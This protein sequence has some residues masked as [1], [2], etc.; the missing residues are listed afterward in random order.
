MKKIP[1]L[2]GIV[3][4]IGLVGMVA[5]TTSAVKNVTTLFSK[6]ASSTFVLPAKAGSISDT[7]F[8][9]YW[10]SDQ[11]NIGVVN[12]GKDNLEN[13]ATEEIKS[14]SHLV[15]ITGLKPQ[16]VYN[17]KVAGGETIQVTTLATLP[18]AANPIYGNILDSNNQ[19]VGDAIV[20]WQS[21]MVT[22]SKSDG[23]FVLPVTEFKIGQVEQIIISKDALTSV[24]DCVYGKDQP[25]P[26]VKLGENVSCES[27]KSTA[28][29]NAPVANLPKEN[30][31][32]APVILTDPILPITVG[33]PSAE[34]T[35]LPPIIEEPPISTPS[36]IPAEPPVTPSSGTLE[37]T[38]A[39]MA[40]GLALVALGLGLLL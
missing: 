33:T 8:S 5:L 9:V 15:R 30:S 18:K 12:Y 19:T 31:P 22:K 40:G 28:S 6:A 17:F 23:S 13:I 10:I 29:F 4:V 3:L 35:P 20:V 34:P 21:T 1:T 7:G 37:T 32:V 2:I 11:P 36:V 14:T 26:T 16:T 24:V 39:I 25:L 27:Q 38:L